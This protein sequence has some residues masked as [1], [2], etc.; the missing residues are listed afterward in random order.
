MK[1]ISTYL[2]VGSFIKIENKIYFMNLAFNGIFYIDLNDFSTHF[3]HKFTFEPASAVAL[4]TG[5]CMYNDGVIY[6]FPNNM[7]AIMEYNIFTKKEMMIEIPY[8]N[9]KNFKFADAI[10]KGD[11]VYIFPFDICKGI[12][13]FYFNE[14]KIEKDEEL[15]LLFNS[16]FRCA[17]VFLVQGNRML[18]GEYGG[19]RIV[20]VD[21]DMKKIV[22]VH[23]I[24]PEIKIFFICYDG[25][26]YWILQ[27]ESLDI[28]EWNYQSNMIQVYTNKKITEEK[29]E[30]IELPPY[31]NLIFLEDEILV[32]NN[33]LKNIWRIHRGKNVI[34]HPINLPEKFQ[35]VKY[36]TFRGWPI[37]DAY[38]ILEEKVLLYSTRGNMMLI[39]DIKTKQLS[40][41]EM[42]VSLDK[43]PYLD[44]VVKEIFEQNNNVI[45]VEQEELYSMEAFVYTVTVKREITRQLCEMDV[46]GKSIYQIM[47]SAQQ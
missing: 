36:S 41:K 47:S 27:T 11:M 40:G 28:Y 30:N 37:C 9:E 8:Q 16:G 24:A 15:S 33:E 2:R 1:K 10:R 35:C 25:N 34:D 20:E 32:L 46:I 44:D 39:Y 45:N 23:I 38:T 19:N 5:G 21:L 14:Q 29:G 43:D 18:M 7:N 3:V 31:S 13:R 17:N 22:K 42:L 26:N 12:Y 4:S 6:F